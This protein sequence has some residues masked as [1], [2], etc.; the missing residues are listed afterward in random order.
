MR[1]A[2][3]S[4]EVLLDG[5]S[6]ATGR[7]LKVLLDGKAFKSGNAVTPG[8]HHLSVEISDVIPVQRDFWTFY[9]SN[10]LGVIALDSYKGS[11]ELV[12]VPPDAGYDLS[13]YGQNWQGNLPAHL[14]SVPAGTYHLTVR[15][16]G[17]ALDHDV[18][19]YRGTIT[20]NTTEFP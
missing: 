10:K 14:N 13:G 6:L 12:T 5:R 2:S 3:L 7:T 16:K 9:G 20:T 15:R 11:I 4:F 19:V 17:W 1:R 8:H 18:T